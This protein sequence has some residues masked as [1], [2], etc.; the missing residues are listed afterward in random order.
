MRKLYLLPLLAVLT[1]SA[2]AQGCTSTATIA[3]PTVAPFSGQTGAGTIVA[4]PEPANYATTGCFGTNNPIGR[5][6]DSNTS[7]NLCIAQ[8][9]DC[10]S[11]HTSSEIVDPGDGEDRNWSNDETQFLTYNNNRA[12]HVWN[13]DAPTM[14]AT[15]CFTHFT[16]AGP[17]VPWYGGAVYSGL[18]SKKIYA[19]SNAAGNATGTVLSSYATTGT[20]P[21]ALSGKGP[22]VIDF[23]AANGVPNTYVN[24]AEPLAVNNADTIFGVALS[25]SVTQNTA[26][27]AATWKSGSG[28]STYNTSTSTVAG[29]WGST[30]AMFCQNCPGHPIDPGHYTIHNMKMS[31][32]GLWAVITPGGGS[33]S[34]T[35]FFG[36]GEYVWQVGTTNIY[37]WI[38]NQSGHYVTGFTGAAD[39]DNSPYFFWHPHGTSTDTQFPTTG[40]YCGNNL[41]S[42]V[43]DSHPSWWWNSGADQEPFLLTTSPGNTNPVY[44][45]CG[46]AELML[47]YS[48]AN[49][50]KSGQLRRLAHNYVATVEFQGAYGLAEI[51]PLGHFVLFTSPMA[52]STTHIG[53]L[54][55]TSGA[56]PCT[57]I[58]NCSS[59]VFVVGMG[60]LP[61]PAPVPAIF[62]QS[63][64]GPLTGC[65][66]PSAGKNTLCS[67]QD[68]WYASAGA[69]A[70][71]RLSVV[72]PVAVP[73]TITC[74][75]ETVSAKGW[76]VLNGCH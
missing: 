53:Q 10:P 23:T 43:Q 21:L 27:Y 64:Q 25:N 33:C 56:Y 3:P 14:I 69:G 40:N 68:G 20:C 39:E 60:A 57:V 8:G 49:V 72:G 4:N 54:G 58:A 36:S 6:S 32:D 41:P 31:G 1:S 50:A 15:G 34:T 35:C 18:T 70:L 47:L 17:A 22:T 65:Q 76:I 16:G 45:G 9:S 2:W 19:F 13:F 51:S 12:I 29:D 11:Q 5:V 66:T 61:T 37:Q 38:T 7:G 59:H 44:S 73:P 52:N 24:L 55:D 46:V 74:S 71:A 67:G 26:V 30:G 42:V 62:A 48:P 75:G 63:P 28:F